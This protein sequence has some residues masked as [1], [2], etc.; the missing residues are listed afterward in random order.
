VIAAT[1]H[2]ERLML[3]KGDLRP[4]VYR[5]QGWISAVVCVDGRMAAVWRY[6]RKGRRL[7]VEVEP[8]PR[9]RLTKAVRAATE[10]EA[11]DLARFMGGELALRW[12]S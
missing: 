3:G 11:D 1:R 12:V 2:A 8:F 7:E 9:V 10:Q 4:L 6:E 5:Q